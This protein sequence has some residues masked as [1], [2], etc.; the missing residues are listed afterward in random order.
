MPVSFCLSLAAVWAGPYRF[1]P[2]PKRVWWPKVNAALR[3]CIACSHSLTSAFFETLSGKLSEKPP[4]ASSDIA[5][6]NAMYVV[7]V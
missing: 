1:T 7:H 3:L 2:H 5:F 4:S 6:L